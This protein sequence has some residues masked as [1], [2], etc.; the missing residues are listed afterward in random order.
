M[1]YPH[2]RR[3]IREAYENHFGPVDTREV[4]AHRVVSIVEKR[5]SMPRPGLEFDRGC[6]DEQ[7]YGGTRNY[8]ESRGY[9][10][11]DCYTSN[12]YFD[13]MPNY[14]SFRR[15]SS[16]PRNE[17]SYSQQCYSKDDLRHQLSSRSSRAQQ[18][19]K[20]GRGTGSSQRNSK[21]SVIPRD[22][23]P[24]R[25]DVQPP[26][27]S[28]SGSNASSKNFSPDRE[29]GYTY[30]QAQQKQSESSLH[31]D[32]GPV[33]N[34]KTAVDEVYL[35]DHGPQDKSS[36]G[37][38]HT[39]SSSVEGS[40][41]SSTSLKEKP[42]ASVT[43]SEEV[44]AASMEPTL[45]PEKD[46]K[47]RRLEAIEAKAQEIEKHYRQDC[48]TFRTVVKMLVTKEPSLENLLQAPL[49]ESLSEIKQRCLDALKSFITELDEILDQEDTST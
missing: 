3:S 18:L 25:K 9:H 35:L 19:R 39:P 12:R 4:T 32:P 21:S 7:W 1:A 24:G 23:S 34:N 13:E 44:A 48:E 2:S 38:S 14:S 27:T 36:A 16:P 17:A 43:E 37:S 42:S 15:N 40:P 10:E 5:S 45:T 49:D 29:K 31:G 6:D 26:Q 30:Q 8:Q 47:A 20:R 22:R 46:L 33:L 41:Q 11:D 28:R